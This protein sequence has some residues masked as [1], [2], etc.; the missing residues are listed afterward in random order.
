MPRVPVGV[1]SYTSPEGT[2][3]GVGAG[4]VV[5]I[6]Q[7]PPCID[8]IC[9]LFLLDFICTLSIMVVTLRSTERST[10]CSQRL[11]RTTPA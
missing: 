2:L 8:Y 11:T 9:T 10:P 4:G 6:Y 5:L 1:E 7:P 3:M